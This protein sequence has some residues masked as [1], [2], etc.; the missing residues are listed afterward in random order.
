MWEVC[1]DRGP[2]Y[3]ALDFPG[4]ASV[5]ELPA[6][7]GDIRDMGSIPGWGRSP[8]GGHGNPLQCS[9]LETPVDRGAWRAAVHGVASPTRCSDLACLHTHTHTHLAL[10]APAPGMEADA[11]HVCEGSGRDH[12]PS[13]GFH[14]RALGHFPSVHTR[15][16]V[17]RTGRVPELHLI[18]CS[19]PPLKLAYALL[20]K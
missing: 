19:L 11:I 17:V 3:L 18:P 16:P 5:K 9:C 13:P 12:N 4:S 6:S 8:G 15:D 2:L 20:G 14:S 1:E 10:Q 7:A